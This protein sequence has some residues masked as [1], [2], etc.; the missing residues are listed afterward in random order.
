MTFPDILQV[1][2]LVLM[3]CRQYLEEATELSQLKRS[4]SEGLG[5]QPPQV[6]ALSTEKETMREGD[7]CRAA[8][9][10]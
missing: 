2:E 1:S 7:T 8:A 5:S 6:E 4:A 10:D 3:K 9:L